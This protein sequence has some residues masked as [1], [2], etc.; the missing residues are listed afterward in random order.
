MLIDHWAQNEVEVAQS[1]GI[2]VHNVPGQ[3]LPNAVKGVVNWSLIPRE[4]PQLTYPDTSTMTDYAF[5]C[6]ECGT[7]D[8]LYVTVLKTCRIDQ[9]DNGSFDTYML[10]IDDDVHAKSHVQCWDCQWEGEMS[11]CATRAGVI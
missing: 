7:D 6:P 4:E 2:V 5:K 10:K 11:E 3:P 1:S 8:E 9:D